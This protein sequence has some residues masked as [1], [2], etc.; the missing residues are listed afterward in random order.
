MVCTPFNILE[1]WMLC[2][3]H[4]SHIKLYG[5]LVNVARSPGETFEESRHRLSQLKIIW[6]KREIGLIDGLLNGLDHANYANG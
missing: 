5:H 3:S 1:Q 2:D 4:S 6:P